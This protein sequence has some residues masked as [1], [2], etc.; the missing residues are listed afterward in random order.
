MPASSAGSLLS[1]VSHVIGG[2]WVTWPPRSQMSSVAFGSGIQEHGE[3]LC[4]QPLQHPRA[5]GAF[6]YLQRCN[7]GQSL[8]FAL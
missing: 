5:R 4:P 3:G 6:L 7:F 2:S 8:T 1:C